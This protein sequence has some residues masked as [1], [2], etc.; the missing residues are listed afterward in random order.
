MSAATRNLP[1]IITFV[2]VI[3]QI[4][5]GG[6]RLGDVLGKPIGE[7]DNYAESWEISDHKEGQS[8]VN[9][10]AFKGM[11]LHEMFTAHKN[12]F[13]QQWNSSVD[14]FPL[15][16][17]FLDANDRLSVQVHP[18]DQQ[19]LRFDPEENGKTEAWYILSSEPESRIYAGLKSGV[20]EDDLRAA[21]RNQ[22][23]EACLHTVAPRAGDC[24]FIPAGTVHA[25]G[26]GVLL[27]EVQQSSDLTF[28]LYDWG[29]VGSD[30]QPRQLHIEEAMQ[31]IDFARG[32]I[33]VQSPTPLKEGPA[34]AR[35][36]VSCPYFSIREFRVTKNVHVPPDDRCHI[37]MCVRGTVNVSVEGTQE[38][39]KLGQTCLIPSD[40][41]DIEFE[42]GD[43]TEAATL[44]DVVIP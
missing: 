37:V 2:P 6:R 33:T 39:L 30:G 1:A 19:A 43:G 12:H 16:I 17:K 7:D 32:P 9:T 18:D 11:P 20:T 5:W 24:F 4:R 23:F 21:I 28:R 27:A 29:R 40:V 36:L 22:D 3:K 38:Q 41:K 10:E 13:V 8:L 14:R 26:E 31:C 35:E 25:I 34:E 42:P 44:L 15:L